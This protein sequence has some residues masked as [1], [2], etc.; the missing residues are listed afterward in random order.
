MG[1]LIKAFK[2]KNLSGFIVEKWKV[3]TNVNRIKCIFT[4]K[5]FIAGTLISLPSGVIQ[6]E[7][8]QIG[9]KV[10]AHTLVNHK[11]CIYDEAIGRYHFTNNSKVDE[12]ASEE[13]LQ[14]DKDIQSKQGLFEIDLSVTE[15]NGDEARVTLLRPR[16]WLI[17]HHISKA[18]D[19]FWFDHKDAG[20]QGAAVVTAINSAHISVNKEKSV[21]EDCVFSTVTA[22]FV[23]NSKDVW[24]LAFDGGDTIGTTSIHPF[25]SLHRGMWIPAGHINIGEQVLSRNGVQTLLSKHPLPGCHQV[26]NMEVLDEHNYT[27]GE[28]GIVVHNAYDIAAFYKLSLKD[29]KA[30]IESIWKDGYPKYFKR[31]H[32]F[33][34][35]IFDK[36]LRSFRSTGDISDNFPRI[37][38][39]SPKNSKWKF[40]DNNVAEVVECT[41]VVSIKSTTRTNLQSWLDDNDEKIPTQLGEIQNNIGLSKNGF[42]SK[43]KNIK[44]EKARFIIA[45]PLGNQTQVTNWLPSLRTL[46][47]SIT[48]EVITG[49][50]LL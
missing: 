42:T 48:F 1:G 21:Y 12:L 49:E 41:E 50:S 18:G 4:G 46:Y 22:T 28:E 44:Y 45:V 24:Q 2:D 6:I 5:C 33:E 39:F 15:L 13:T 25:F 10:L 37:D 11:E 32:F 36:K 9:D 43:Q 47:P 27:I 35:L 26:Y 16:Q 3:I 29:Q 14:N 31:G 17:D 30:F 8:V 19:E 7:N 23:R 40:V 34:G 38:A 20:M